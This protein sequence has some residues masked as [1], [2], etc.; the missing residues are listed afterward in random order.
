MLEVFMMLRDSF[1]MWLTERE[2]GSLMRAGGIRGEHL[3]VVHGRWLRSLKELRPH[4]VSLVDCF[5]VR[6]GLLMSTLGHSEGG[7]YERIMDH[8]VQKNPT[9][10]KDSY[11]GFEKYIRP[12]L[13]PKI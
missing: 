4:L 1:V 13:K 7:I 11:A 12:M 3:E 6:D 2:S 10:G 5:L 9:A 8:V